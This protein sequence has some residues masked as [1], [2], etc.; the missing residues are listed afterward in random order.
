M[1]ISDNF[2]FIE[3][4]DLGINHEGEFECIFAEVKGNINEKNLIV[5]QI[6]RPPNTNERC[7]I[8]RYEQVMSG[9]CNT[10]NNIIIGTDQNFDLM[11]IN[12][13]TNV[14]DLFDVFLTLGVVPAI[15]RPTRITHTSAT[16][17]DNLYIQYENYENV[18]SRILTTDVSDHLPI[19]VCMGKHNIE[20]KKNPL[21][22]S[23]RPMNANNISNVATALMNISWDDLDEQ[24]TAND[25]Y[26]M[27][28]DTFTQTLDLHAPVKTVSIPYKAIIREAW[29]SNGLLKSSRTRDKL[30][31]KC[32]GKSKKDKIYVQYVTYRNI[33]NS[34]KRTAKEAYYTKLL[35]KHKCD[36][37]KTWKT[38]NSI[39]GR[40]RDKSSLSDIFVVNGK[41]ET[42]TIQIANLFSEYFT[43]V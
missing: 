32:L 43:N 41:R 39:I 4:P 11:K 33:F 2:S 27:F 40:T 7:A 9:I 30:Y 25:S 8:S 18:Q 37:R 16:L 13:N 31:K 22:F 29:M 15:T 38:I 1:Y 23:Y 5:G 3:R 17:I 14:S 20:H 42:D 21:T 36:I 12:Q 35:D 6:Y 28:M 24:R 26:T 10:K 34:L 19:I